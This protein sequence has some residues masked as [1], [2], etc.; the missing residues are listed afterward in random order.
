MSEDLNIQ[1]G[2]KYLTFSG[3]VIDIHYVSNHKGYRWYGRNND[4]KRK[5]YHYNDEG[6]LYTV[7]GVH[8]DKT[9]NLLKEVN[10]INNPEYFL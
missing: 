3:I 4:N 6:L 5:N 7:L 8:G 10:E 2:K 9:L 1:L